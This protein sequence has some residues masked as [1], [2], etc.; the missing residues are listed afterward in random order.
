M[1]FAATPAPPDRELTRFADAVERSTLPVASMIR[2]GTAFTSWEAAL[3]A[4]AMSGDGDACVVVLDELPY[5]VDGRPD[6]EAQLQHVWDQVLEHHPVL[7]VAIGSDLAMM[8]A[9]T[10]TGGRCSA[11]LPVRSCSVH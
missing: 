1:F 3:S 10:A 9:L 11:G 4:V 7:L 6:V 2:S 8:S 5:L